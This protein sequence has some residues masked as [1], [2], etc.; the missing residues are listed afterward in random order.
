[1]MPALSGTRRIRSRNRIKLRLRPRIHPRRDERGSFTF[2]VV[3]WLLMTMMLA[4]LVVD[5]ALSIT[6]RQRVG[7]IAEQ[8]A[9]AAANDLNQDELRQ[10]RYVIAGD[11]QSQATAVAVASG[12]DPSAVVC[13]Q[14]APILLATGQLVPVVQCHVTFT[15]M[16][17]LA[18][19]FYH[20]SFIA[21]AVASAHPQPGF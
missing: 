19:L 20:G 16:P 14:T 5:G 2:A 9:R 3:F 6:T 10:G 1:M 17:I 21:N 12:L 7:N 4:G 18:G 11:F 15:Y 13:R 8:A